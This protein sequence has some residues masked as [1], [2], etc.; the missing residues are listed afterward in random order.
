MVPTSLL[1]I[2]TTELMDSEKALL[3]LEIFS[4]SLRE[5]Y[6]GRTP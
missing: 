6:N 5:T 4:L 2:F 1:P 3:L